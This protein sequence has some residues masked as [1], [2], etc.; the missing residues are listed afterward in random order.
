MLLT[1]A[2][3]EM[4]SYTSIVDVK[5]G[6]DGLESLTGRAFE[7]ASRQANADNF[8]M[9]CIPTHVQHVHEWLA[10]ATPSPSLYRRCRGKSP[11]VLMRVSSSGAGA[12]AG[13]SLRDIW[14]T[15][16]A[17]TGRPGLHRSEPFGRTVADVVR[18]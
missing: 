17:V 13:C 5:P 16:L 2:L 6:R 15:W 4:G 12:A 11:L 18:P 1:G 9:K 3:F 14:S 10:R 7:D 8:I